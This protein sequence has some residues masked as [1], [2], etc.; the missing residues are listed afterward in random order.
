M[1]W[2]AIC[3]VPEWEVNSHLCQCPQAG[4]FLGWFSF[5]FCDCFFVSSSRNCRSLVKICSNSV[6]VNPIIVDITQ[7]HYRKAELPRNYKEN[8]C[9]SLLDSNSKSNAFHICKYS[10]DCKFWSNP[11]IL[12][13]NIDLESY[14]PNG[15]VTCGWTTLKKFLWH[16]ADLG[17]DIVGQIVDPST[18]CTWI[19]LCC[20]CYCRIFCSGNRSECLK[21]LPSR[22][23]DFTCK[24]HNTG[25]WLCSRTISAVNLKGSRE[26]VCGKSGAQVVVA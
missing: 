23:E 13:W 16:F 7:N 4:N 24:L 12:G 26:L 17:L 22:L 10:N 21:F 11:L 14:V 15:F 5:N 9:F 18:S 2:L 3:R 8:C 19:S 20:E 25:V 1:H 6:D